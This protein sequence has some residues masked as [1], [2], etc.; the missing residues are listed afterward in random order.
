MPLRSKMLPRSAARAMLAHPLVGALLGVDGGRDGLHLGQAGDD[1]DEPQRHHHE[2]G[3]DPAAGQA[4][5]REAAPGSLRRRRRGR[6]GPAVREVP[7]VRVGPAGLRAGG[8]VGLHFRPVPAGKRRTCVG[9]GGRRA[10]QVG[11][12]GRRHHPQAL[13]RRWPRSAP[14]PRGGP[15]RAGGARSA[16]ARRR[17]ASCSRS[18]RNWSGPAYMESGRPEDRAHGEHDGDEE[19][20]PQVAVRRRALAAAAGC[21]LGPSPRQRLAVPA[22]GVAARPALPCGYRL[23]LASP[24]GGWSRSWP[25]SADSTTRRRALSDRGLAAISSCDGRS[26]RRVTA[27]RAGG[28]GWSGGSGSPDGTSRRRGPVDEAVLHHAVLDRVVGEDG[29]A[30]RRAP[31]RRTRRR[32][33]R[34]RWSNSALT[35]M[36]MAWKVRRAG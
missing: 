11:D 23:L 10:V 7:A 2:E 17:P 3:N 29:Q 8:K 5:G 15:P 13:L 28:G 12:L 35:S 18:R 6:L 36:R 32:G 34:S 22:P 27:T 30:A 24:G 14:A 25:A 16:A 26:A 9:G 33:R 19:G 31:G 21:W 1:G 4:A 20:Q